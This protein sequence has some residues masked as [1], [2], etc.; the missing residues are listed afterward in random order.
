MTSMGNPV[1]QV[2]LELLLYAGA[3]AV[4][5][6]AGL[7]L[8]V[9]RR[10]DAAVSLGQRLSL[11]LA[12]PAV[13]FQAV[14]GLADI[15]SGLLVEHGFF[16]LHF[17]REALGW[18]GLAIAAWLTD[19][20]ISFYAYFILALLAQRTARRARSE[21]EASAD[22]PIDVN[23]GTEDAFAVRLAIAAVSVGLLQSGLHVY[24]WQAD[25]WSTSATL[26]FFAASTLIA[27]VLLLGVQG[28]GVWRK[29]AGVSETA[30]VIVLLTIPLLEPF[31][32]NAIQLFAFV[33]L[34]INLLRRIREP[35]VAA[36]EHLFACQ[37]TRLHTFSM[38]YLASMALVYMML[39]PH[40]AFLSPI[41]NFYNLPVTAAAAVQLPVILVLATLLN[42]GT[43][44]YLLLAIGIG[45]DL[46]ARLLLLAGPVLLD[47]EKPVG[48]W[49]TLG[50]GGLFDATA[51]FFVLVFVQ[52][53]VLFA[54]YALGEPPNAFN[55]EAFRRVAGRA[56]NLDRVTNA[57]MLMFAVL[58][59]GFLHSHNAREAIG[60]I[61]AEV[62]RN[63]QQFEEMRSDDR[64]PSTVSEITRYR[65]AMKAAVNELRQTVALAYWPPPIA[66][67]AVVGL[68]VLWG[69]ITP[70]LLVKRVR[71]E[72][73]DA[74]AKDAE[75]WLIEEPAMV[76]LKWQMRLE[77][78]AAIGLAIGAIFAI[79]WVNWLP[80]EAKL[81]ELHAAALALIEGP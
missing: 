4:V 15:G 24:V 66:G 58:A 62:D 48:I 80:V 27:S 52:A 45:F 56:Q 18:P 8:L 12:W 59:L 68:L 69:R 26:G 25:A 7:Y 11:W 10:H 39:F 72:W 29:R 17:L 64:V 53:I 76:R 42:R 37:D 63:V 67:I 71:N 70:T 38:A 9:V 21:S 1:M 74:A 34:V 33:A 14:Y 75:R 40:L 44:G 51:W 3:T 41:D 30:V 28:L 6:L 50:P 61:Q 55:K 13:V 47:P 54:V 20:L 43:V 46:A 73:G 57:G 79:S 19:L 60:S 2:Q 23:S 5:A 49:E 16:A 32:G 22:A 77:P 35:G 78:L 36:V 65:D 81:D 31:L